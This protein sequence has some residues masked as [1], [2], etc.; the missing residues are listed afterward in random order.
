ML[1]YVTTEENIW[2]DC[3]KG[4]SKVQKLTGSG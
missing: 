3:W 4:N 1:G 2:F